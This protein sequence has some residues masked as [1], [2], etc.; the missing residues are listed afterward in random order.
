MKAVGSS[1]IPVFRPC[2]LESQVLH[3][4][5]LLWELLERIPLLRDFFKAHAVQGRSL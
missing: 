1:N 4:A 3:F 2:L 5:I